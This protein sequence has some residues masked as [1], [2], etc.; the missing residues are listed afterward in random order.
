MGTLIKIMK[1]IF[2]IMSLFLFLASCSSNEFIVTKTEL[3]ERL[4]KDNFEKKGFFWSYIGSDEQY[5]YFERQ[6]MQLF[7]KTFG[8]TNDGLYKLLKDKNF[9][10]G[11]PEVLYQN[12]SQTLLDCFTYWEMDKNSKKQTLRY[13]INIG[14]IP[15]AFPSPM[16]EQGK[17]VANRNNWE[18]EEG[19]SWFEWKSYL[20]KKFGK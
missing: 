5:H 17:D 1:Q 2:V 19:E 16:I 10:L 9:N 18:I 13:D 3:Q 11:H 14:V 20:E 4:K 6:E 7:G 15:F 8:D 12:P